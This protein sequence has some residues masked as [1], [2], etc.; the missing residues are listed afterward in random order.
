ML[1]YPCGARIGATFPPSKV[2]GLASRST[3]RG[4]RAGGCRL[5]RGRLRCSLWPCRSHLGP[6]S[7]DITR[8]A[9]LRNLKS[10]AFRPNCS[11]AK[12]NAFFQIT[13]FS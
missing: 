10:G 11:V 6:W 1:L 8:V 2:R 13:T 3:R 12:W 5:L 4:G 7:S 9:V